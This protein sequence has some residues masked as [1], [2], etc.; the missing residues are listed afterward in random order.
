MKES[1]HRVP[2]A[3]GREPARA[4]AGVRARR[5][6]VQAGRAGRVEQR[7]EEAERRLARGDEEVVE[8]RDHT[9]DSLRGGRAGFSNARVR[10]KRGREGAYGRGAG[11]AVDGGGAPIDDDL[12]VLRLGCDV[13]EAAAA[14]AIDPNIISIN[15]HQNA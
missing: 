2:S 7:V 12:E 8:Q 6:V 10:G 3:H 15:N 5:D 14:G 1:T 13:R 9:R 11:G 4:A